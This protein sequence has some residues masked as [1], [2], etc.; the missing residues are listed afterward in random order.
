[1]KTSVPFFLV[2]LFI[3]VG[4][5]FVASGDATAQGGGGDTSR[6]LIAVTGTYGSGASVLYVIDAKTRHMA[7]YKATNGSHLE[8]IAARDITWDLRLE[9]WNDRSDPGVS[10]KELRK[11]WNESNT[12]R[13]GNA[14]SRPTGGPAESGR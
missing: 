4:L 2:V 9:E 12:N 11:I 6:D 1:M 13:S 10:P 7:V 14:T 3:V 5:A 8:F